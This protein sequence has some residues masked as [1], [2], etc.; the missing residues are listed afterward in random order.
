MENKFVP[1]IIIGAIVGGAVTLADKSTR[2]A[3]VQSFKDIKEGNRSRKP[4]KITSIKNEVLY[5]KDTIEEIRRNNPE[6]E[7]SIKD[8][9]DTFVNRKNNR[10]S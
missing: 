2:N 1:G 9:K 8:A 10:L 7:K 5:W 6:L 3:L 4:S